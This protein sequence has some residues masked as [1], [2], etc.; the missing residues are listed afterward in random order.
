MIL[1]LLTMLVD[2]H[3]VYQMPLTGEY[4]LTMVIIF[5]TTFV[6]LVSCTMVIHYIS[7]LHLGL[8]LLNLEKKKLFGRMHEGTLILSKVISDRTQ[9]KTMTSLDRAINE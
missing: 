7:R 5:P 6:L 4:I 8:N 9:D 1:T 3:A 2:R